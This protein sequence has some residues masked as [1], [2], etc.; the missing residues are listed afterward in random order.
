[1]PSSLGERLAVAC[2]WSPREYGPDGEVVKWCDTRLEH[3][4]GG[5]MEQLRTTPDP[6]GSWQDFGQMLEWATERGLRIEIQS[7]RWFG[8]VKVI[9]EAADGYYD[10]ASTARVDGKWPAIR[11]VVSECVL[12]VIEKMETLDAD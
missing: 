8:Y 4:T 7:W 2:G 6:E 9:G 12:E 5:S 3:P 1:M 11:R 10:P